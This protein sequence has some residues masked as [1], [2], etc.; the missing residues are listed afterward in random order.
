[1]HGLDEAFVW[2]VTDPAQVGLVADSPE[3]RHIAHEMTSTLF[4][5]ATCGNPGWPTYAVGEPATR[6]F[7]ATE[8]RLADVD[9]TFLEAWDGVERR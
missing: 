3:T 9:S 2:G 6:L 7:G 5:F 1:M 4:Q 8:E